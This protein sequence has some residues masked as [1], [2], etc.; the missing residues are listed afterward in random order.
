MFTLLTITCLLHQTTFL[1]LSRLSCDGSMASFCEQTVTDI[2]SLSKHSSQP[3]VLQL[4][5]LPN[6]HFT[7]SKPVSNQKLQTIIQQCQL[8][9]G[10]PLN[11]FKVS[12]SCFST[13]KLIKRQILIIRPNTTLMT[14]TKTTTTITSMRPT[15]HLSFKPDQMLIIKRS[16]LTDSLCRR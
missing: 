1:V 11:F 8:N 7:Q 13:F 10:T 14:T 12:R 3:S 6:R 16:R 15:R 2:L 9:I 5:V 4:C